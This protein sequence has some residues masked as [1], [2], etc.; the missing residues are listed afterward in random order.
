[1]ARHQVV[2]HIKIVDKCSPPLRRLRF[3]ILLT[4]YG[5]NKVKKSHR[6]DELSNRT[7]AHPGC[8]KK[9]KQR[10]VDLKDATY[11]YEHHCQKESGRGHNIGIFG[12][13]RKSRIAAGLSVKSYR[14]QVAT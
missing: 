14:Q 11:C 6:H 7:C 8:V 2:Y 1:M 12:K 10:L 9:I 4:D 3:K 13:P 5:G